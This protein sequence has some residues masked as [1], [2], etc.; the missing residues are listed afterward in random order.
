VLPDEVWH[1][2]LDVDPTGVMRT[3][4]AA[5]PVL[6]AARR[7]GRDLQHRRR[8]RRLARPHPLRRVHGEELAE[9]FRAVPA[10]PGPHLI[11]AVLPRG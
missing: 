4:R 9:Q 5:A 2:I 7:G 3:V 1:R 10:E 8:G 11:D 6:P